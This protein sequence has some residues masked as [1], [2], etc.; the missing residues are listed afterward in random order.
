[1][2]QNLFALLSGTLFGVGL[3][4]SQMTDRGRVIGFLDVT[5]TWDPTLIFV[6]GGAVAV[7]VIAF[8]FILRRESPFG[9]SQFYL[10]TRNDVDMRLLGGAAIFGIGWGIAG[11]CPGPGLVSLTGASWN[12]IL[13]V[14]SM[15]GGAWIF[16]LLMVQRANTFIKENAVE[17]MTKKKSRRSIGVA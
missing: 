15:L 9:D 14:F 2:K 6:L 8:R 5:G 12:A 10:P 17:P 1:M 7:T 16:Q 4:L 3:A 13:F 11:F